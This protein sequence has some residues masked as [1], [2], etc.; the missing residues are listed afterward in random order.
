MS[1]NSKIDKSAT[2]LQLSSVHQS[3]RQELALAEV[4]DHQTKVHYGIEPYLKMAYFYVP[5]K[6]ELAQGF[7]QDNWRMIH[8]CLRP[9]TTRRK[10]DINE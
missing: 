8:F 9:N 10:R 2:K 3:V 5:K 7:T 6:K 1:S 4:K